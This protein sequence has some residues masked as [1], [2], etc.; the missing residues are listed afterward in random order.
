MIYLVQK[1]LA[2]HETQPF[3]FAKLLTF[4]V[5]PFFNSQPLLIQT[6]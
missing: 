1:A 2:I 4:P 5:S 6:K 3:V